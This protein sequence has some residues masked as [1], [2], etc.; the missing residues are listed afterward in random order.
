M[1]SHSTS[2]PN[3]HDV[4]AA[5]VQGQRHISTTMCPWQPAAWPHTAWQAA[6]CT[7]LKHQHLAAS[8][9]CWPCRVG[10]EATLTALPE[11]FATPALA[12]YQVSTTASQRQPRRLARSASALGQ[13]SISASP[14]QPRRLATSAS[15]PRQ[16]SLAASPDQRQCLTSS[17]LVERSDRAFNGAVVIGVAVTD[18]AKCEH[19][20]A[21]ARPARDACHDDRLAA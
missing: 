14:R 5:L 6:L 3:Q 16:I 2:A 9:L 1:P 13:V 11:R 8:A 12:L 15:M 17:A 20:P 4:S 18:Q 21:P 19:V 10:V 7:T